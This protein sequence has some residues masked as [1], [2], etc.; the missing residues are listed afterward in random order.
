VGVAESNEFYVR[1]WG[2]RGS[3]AC[4]GPRTMR[5]GGNTSCLEMRCGDNMLIFDAGTGLHALGTRIGQ[6]QRLRADLFFSHTH[7]DHICGFSFFGPAFLPDNELRIWAGHLLP[8]RTV[9]EV[10]IYLM[11]DPLFPVPI[12]TMRAEMSFRDFTAG[13]TLNPDNRVN[14]RTAPLNHPN[15]AT[16][17]RVE[18]EGQTICYVT[19]TEH[20]P[21]QIDDNI[22]GL[23]EDADIFIYD[24][25][26]TDVE[27]P[28]HVNW[29]HSTWQQGA[30]LADE[31]NVKTFV[32]FHHDPDHDDDFMDGIATDVARAR[33]GS[34]VAQ[35]GMT[36]RP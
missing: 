28:S 19:D 15:G 11:M 3:I 25:T 18:F 24:S 36:L 29:G 26:Y 23:I 30:R 27:Y 34:V 31:A 16:G 10:L 8:D 9:R 14:I 5:Y 12:D 35:E 4:P 21:D 6:G 32:V 7:F 22:L 17:Y 13:D 33:P 1:F 20:F 2:V